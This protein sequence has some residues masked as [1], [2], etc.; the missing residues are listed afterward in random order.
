MPARAAL[1]LGEL[2]AHLLRR[3][4]HEARRE[5]LG[6]GQPARADELAPQHRVGQRPADARAGLALVAHAPPR[7]PQV[8]RVRRLGGA[9]VAGGHRG[10]RRVVVLA[11]R[12]V[13]DVEDA[14]GRVGYFGRH[15]PTSAERIRSASA[16]SV[17]VVVRRLVLALEPLVARDRLGEVARRALVDARRPRR[18]ARRRSLPF[19]R[20]RSWSSPASSYPGQRGVGVEGMGLLVVVAGL[21]GL[22]LRRAGR[23]GTASPHARGAAGGHRRRAR[24]HRVPRV[25]RRRRGAADPRAGA[26]S[27]PAL[28]RPAARRA[29][30]R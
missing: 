15:E 4:P 9:Q 8:E 12:R 21:Y 23:T 14:I 27:D 26:R 7:R 25:P 13:A 19:S 16:C 5:P 20:P 17:R 30:S 29:R 24:G 18:R 2:R 6:L 28:D 3:H 11:R 10:R 22:R 1:R